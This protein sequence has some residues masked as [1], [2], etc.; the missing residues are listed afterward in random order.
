MHEEGKADAVPALRPF[1]HLQVPVGVA[2]CR[3][4]LLADVHLDADWLDDLE[5]GGLAAGE[6]AFEVALEERGKRLLIPPLR[7]HWGK[8]LDAVER[9][10]ELKIDRLLGP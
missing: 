5:N 10:R 3:N 9:E 8:H 4:R 6:C 1:E 2:E 7:M